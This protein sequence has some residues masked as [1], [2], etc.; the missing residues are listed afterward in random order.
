MAKK[1]LYVHEAERLYVV[2]RLSY[3]EIAS[4]LPVNERTLRTWSDQGDWMNK[5]RQY[6]ES[7]RAFHE[8]LYEFA[9]ALM[10]SVREDLKDGNEV[11]ASRL[12]GIANI[13]ASLKKTKDYEDVVRAKG[14]DEKPQDQQMQKNLS[15]VTL[16][17]IEALL[18]IRPEPAA[19]PK[20]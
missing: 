7:R 13:I 19:K 15:D 20:A 10:E 18:G 1:E 11:S 12:F 14:S 8:E 16:A 2:E 4:R 5:R 17:Q 3:A 6:M 9:R